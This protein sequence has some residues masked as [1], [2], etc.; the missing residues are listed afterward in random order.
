MA[1]FTGLKNLLGVG[2]S[3]EKSAINAVLEKETL[4]MATDSGIF[5]VN[6]TEVWQHTIYC[7]GRYIPVQTLTDFYDLARELNGDIEPSAK[8]K[9]LGAFKRKLDAG[10]ILMNLDNDISCAGPSGEQHDAFH[11]RYRSICAGIAATMTKNNIKDEPNGI[12]S[13][14][15]GYWNNVDSTK[16]LVKMYKECTGKTDKQ[17]RDTFSYLDCG[18]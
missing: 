14:Q 16:E 7:E 11:L 10:H 1:M 13:R 17:V 4:E 8:Q 3:K 18:L 15:L 9:L 12:I 2:I 5:D 6:G